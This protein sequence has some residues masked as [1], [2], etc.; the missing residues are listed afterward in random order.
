[1][2]LLLAQKSS[3]RTQRTMTRTYRRKINRDT[4]HFCMNCRHWPKTDY[5]SRKRKPKSGEMCDEC[6]SKRS[7]GRCK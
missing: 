3:E 5:E 7:K 1:M 2:A 4:W 6:K